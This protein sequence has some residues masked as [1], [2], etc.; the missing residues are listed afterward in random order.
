MVKKLTLRSYS[1]INLFLSIGAKSGDLHNINSLVQTIGLH[2][3]IAIE[4]S[5]NVNI[6][7][8]VKELSGCSN[9][10]FKAIEEL[11]NFHP[12]NG[13]KIVIEKHVPDG[14]G[15]GGGSANAAAAL[16]G[17]CKLYGIQPDGDTLAN[18]ASKI[19]SDVP[20]FLVGGFM[21]VGGQGER[22]SKKGPQ[23]F[24]QNIMIFKPEY[25]VST[26]QA[27]EEFDEMFK[28]PRLMDPP[29]TFSLNNF[30]N[31]FEPVI[32]RDYPELGEV[33]QLMLDN[34]FLV[35]GLSGSGSAL[36]G[37]Y[38]NQEIADK[39][40]EQLFK[41]GYKGVTYITKAVDCGYKFM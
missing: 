19:G 36:F 37:I 12:F 38:E 14:A 25:S 32:F 18:I 7:C 8:N 31:D 3:T 5:N 17:V 34:G 6:E 16:V 29:K 26:K 33:K 39:F 15:L 1:K 22:I 13:V 28:A 10:V 30:T 20:L 35:A 9:I 21:E 11:R 40:S 27:Y 2:D 41:K 23:A 24:G 4:R